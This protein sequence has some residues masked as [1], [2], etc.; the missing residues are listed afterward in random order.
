MTAAAGS[1]ARALR[2]LRNDCFYSSVS[3]RFGRSV[4]RGLSVDSSSA[5]DFITPRSLLGGV[6]RHASDEDRIHCLLCG[7]FDPLVGICAPCG[8]ATHYESVK[9][10][11]SSSSYDDVFHDCRGGDPTL[12]GL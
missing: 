9:S 12:R 2:S 10:I 4:H 11:P 3:S 1:G 6:A 5:H 8:M 7:V